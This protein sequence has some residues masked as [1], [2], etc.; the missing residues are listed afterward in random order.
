MQY[1]IRE[2]AIDYQCLP[3]MQSK[4]IE[5]VLRCKICQNCN[6]KLLPAFFQV[7]SEISNLIERDGLS[8]NNFTD[9]TRP[10]AFHKI[11]YSLQNHY[12]S[13]KEIVTKASE[14]INHKNQIKKCHSPFVELSRSLWNSR[15]W[16]SRNSCRNKRRYSY[17]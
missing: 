16:L 4:M 10:K 17:R 3:N 6:N 8:K 13:F 12:L 9:L 5:K 7:L 15:W 2:N 14:E 11:Y 1:F